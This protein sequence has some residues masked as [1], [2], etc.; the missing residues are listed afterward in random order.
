M[1]SL[2]ADCS[3]VGRVDRHRLPVGLL[4][5]SRFL[6]RPVRPEKKRLKF[7]FLPFL[8]QKFSFFFIFC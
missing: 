1:L 6:D 4:I 7:S 5:W 2:K 3:Q 8:V